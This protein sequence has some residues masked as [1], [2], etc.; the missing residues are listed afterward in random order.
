VRKVAA[1]RGGKEGNNAFASD[2]QQYQNNTYVETEAMIRVLM[3]SPEVKKETIDWLILNY[4][5]FESA[6]SNYIYLA[7][8]VLPPFVFCLSFSL[9]F[10]FLF[11]S[12][13]LTLCRGSAGGQQEAGRFLRRMVREQ[14][15]V[16]LQLPPQAGSA[17]R[18]QG[19]R[20]VQVR[21]F[22]PF[23]GDRGNDA[24]LPTPRY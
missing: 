5:D 17:Q 24:L 1:S 18:R 2:T 8:Y 9:L 21:A 4:P 16:W 15:R 6:V 20:P 10:L 22:L 13:F 23:L 7:A 3:Q 19:L 12:F 14:G 11:S